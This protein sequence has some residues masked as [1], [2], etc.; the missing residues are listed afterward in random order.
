MNANTVIMYNNSFVFEKYK[1]W[2]SS[3]PNLSTYNFNHI[4]SRKSKE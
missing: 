1:K 3:K 2:N 4:K